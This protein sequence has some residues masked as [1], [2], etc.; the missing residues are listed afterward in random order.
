M[1]ILITGSKGFIG[2]NLNIRLTE[3]GHEVIQYNRLDKD[4]EMKI[5]KSD[6]IFH[7][8][9]VNRSKEDSDYVE[10]NENLTQ[11]IV[12]IIENT[13]TKKPI[14][15]TSSTQAVQDTLYGKSKKKSEEIL[16][17]YNKKTHNIVRII[18]LPGVFGKWS[19]PY[20]N[21]VVATFINQTQ[22]NKNLT[23][24]DKKSNIKLIYIDDAINLLINQISMKST[25]II[26]EINPTFELTVGT[27]SKK[28]QKFKEF[29]NANIIP[30]LTKSID[31]R[32]FSTYT[33][34]KKR[35]N[36]IKRLDKIE[37]ERGYFVE[38][39]KSDSFGQISVNIINPGCVKGNHY[40]HH[41]HEKFI[42]LNGQSTIK[43]RQCY[44]SEIESIC[45]SEKKI[46]II[47]IPPGYVHS[48]ENRSESPAIFL[49]WSNEIFDIE[50]TDTKYEKV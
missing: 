30:S 3:N 24:N 46:E 27:L 19:K 47:D 36:I 38:L 15:F 10:A 6:V 17:D 28:I 44:S 9:A 41:K 48:I 26:S 37:D 5:L 20:Y 18:R 49:I 14:I 2:K 23:I 11:K 31:K 21:S 25:A 13:N 34:F 45:V 50:K 39:L 22:L 32:L 35:E 8:A 1:K 43:L 4:L 16:M 29:E 40:H 42:I 33:S 7:L 12:N